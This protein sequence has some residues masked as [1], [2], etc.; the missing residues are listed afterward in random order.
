MSIAEIESMTVTERLQAIEL[1]W[2]SVSQ[3]ETQVAS[4]AWHGDVLDA[5]RKKVEAGQGAFLSLSELRKR[6]QKG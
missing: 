6:L 3:I 2:T 5:R 4:P 1:L